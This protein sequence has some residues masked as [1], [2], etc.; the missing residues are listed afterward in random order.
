[1]NIVHPDYS[2]LAARVAISNL[3][4]KTSA[5]FLEVSQALNSMKDKAGRDASFIA[6]DV[7]EIIEKNTENF[8]V[9]GNSFYL[10]DR[11]ND[12]SF[13]HPESVYCP[14]SRVNG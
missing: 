3:H 14:I 5:S 1:M 9:G 12:K 6:K 8:Q 10:Y 4:K 2:K 13:C 11:Q 7:F